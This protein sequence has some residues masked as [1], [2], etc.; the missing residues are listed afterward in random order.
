MTDM[1][2]WDIASYPDE[3][4]FQARIHPTLPALAAQP[5][6]RSRSRAT[7]PD[8]GQPVDSWALEGETI[9]SPYTGRAFRQGPTGYFGAKERDADGRIIR[10]G[11]DPLKYDLPV[12]TARL[13]R[14]PMDAAAR[15]FVSIPG[16]L[17]Q[18]YHFAAANW[19]RFYGLL[20]EHMSPEW[21]RALAAAVA[22]Y[23]ETRLPSDGAREHQAR[24]TVH[25]LVGEPG[26]CVLGG[27]QADG[28]TENHKTMW[29]TSGLLYA[30]WFMPDGMVSGHPAPVAAARISERL[31][32]FLARLLVTGNGEYD[33]TIYYLYAIIG[34]LNLFDFSPDP[35]D[36]QLAKLMLDY[37]LATYGLKLFAGL[38]A[39]PS[40]RGGN[41]GYACSATDL[42][43]WMYAPQPG[44]PVGEVPVAGIH[45]ATT[46]YRPNRVI[47]NLLT[48]NVPLPFAATIARPS[49]HMDRPNTFHEYYWRHADYALGS[50]VLEE[51]DNPGQQ[52]VWSLTTRGTASNCVFG[53]GQP[54]FGGIMGYSAH[55]QTLQHQGTL[56]LLTGPRDGE[57]WEVFPREMPA[58]ARWARRAVA[59]ESWLY[60][61]A[62]ARL[63]ITPW[64]VA[65]ETASAWVALHP[66]SSG[67]FFLDGPAADPAL[68]EILCKY[69][70]LVVPGDLTG[71]VVEAA[72]RGDG[73]DFAAFIRA[74]GEPGRL[75]L[76]CWPTEGRLRYHTRDDHDMIAVYRH[77]R[78]YCAGWID[79]SPVDW[80]HWANG[81]AYDSPHLR[82]GQGTMQLSDG[83]EAYSVRHTGAEFQIV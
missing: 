30:R 17:C 53:G 36:R 28:G 50:V 14:D 64:G 48:G 44:L 40:K 49:Y 45:Q 73:G 68:A 1:H 65:A 71:C 37:Y 56:M 80:A 46:A 31:D 20:G 52:T 13:L 75:D 59:A 38:H 69:R 19:A 51:E 62:G 6:P 27:G 15:A 77:D 29:R 35:R 63:E 4:G 32:D 41:D 25:D 82:I 43:L 57:A 81:L 55:D 33:S 23:A 11:G 18:Q 74:M 10:F 67:W 3:A 24:G 70:V 2:C 39:G 21:R 76:S 72:G 16:N 34:Y 7:C 66:L 47:H 12:V 60:L 26:D 79:Q 5:F 83:R 58:D 61:P 42:F 22:S 8:T 78:L 9:I 54:R